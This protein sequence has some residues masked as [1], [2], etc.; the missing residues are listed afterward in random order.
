MITNRKL[1]NV[2]VLLESCDN[3]HVSVACKVGGIF[4]GKIE[5]LEGENR[6]VSFGVTELI[7]SDVGTGN[8]WEF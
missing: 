4:C 5:F 1:R 7:N 2:F 6:E 8:T 3:N